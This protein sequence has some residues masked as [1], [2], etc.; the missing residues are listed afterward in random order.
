MSKLLHSIARPTA[1]AILFGALACFG[2]AAAAAGTADSPAAAVRVA[3]AT[4]TPKAP[5]QTNATKPPVDRTEAWVKELH[6][7]LRITAEQEPAWSAVAQVMRDNAK[8][9]G[10][11]MQERSAMLKSGSAVDNLNGSA[12]M[13]EAH[14]DGLKKFIPVFSTLYD[15]L[16]PAQKKLADAAFSRRMRHR[17]MKRG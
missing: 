4:V 14:L 3:D 8:T 2:T 1:A 16:A 6:G 7:K 13:V 15:S 5:A 10:A 17:H 9:M 12:K 11:M